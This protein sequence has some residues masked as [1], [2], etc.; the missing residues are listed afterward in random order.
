MESAQGRVRGG[1]LQAGREEERKPA[2]ESTDGEVRRIQG[3]GSS[4]HM[5]TLRRV[6]SEA[7]WKLKARAA[8]VDPRVRNR[9]THVLA[10]APAPAPH[11]CTELPP[12]AR[13][14][15]CVW[16]TREAQAGAR[17]IVGPDVPYLSPTWTYCPRATGEIGTTELDG[18]GLTCAR[19]AAT[20]EQRVYVCVPVGTVRTCSCA[21]TCARG[22]AP[23]CVCLCAPVCVPAPV[24]TFVCVCWGGG[25]KE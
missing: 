12:E 16:G 5:R 23:V 14:W 15:L 22:Q 1:V 6:P 9:G 17:E 21:P 8:G 13:V 7:T 18:E 25:D 24:C 4:G 10:R 3:A 19:D 11:P 2:L 20:R